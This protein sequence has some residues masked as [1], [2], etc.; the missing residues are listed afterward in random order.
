LA[1]QITWLF[2]L[3]LAA[4]VSAGRFRWGIPA[5]PSGMAVFLWTGWLLTH[6]IVFSWAKGIFHEY[7][8]TIM[9]PAVAALA[10]MSVVALWKQWFHGGR[11]RGFLLPVALALTA[12]WQAYILRNNYPNASRWLLPMVLAGV[13]TATVG[14]LGLRW[15]SRYRWLT[16]CAKLAAGVGVAVLLI[17][18]ASWSLATLARPGNAVMPAAPEPTW[19]SDRPDRGP[20]RRL[21]FDAAVDGKSRL[22]DFLRANRREE[23]FLMVG[24]SVGPIAPIIIATGEPAI[25]LG[26]FLGADPVVTK[27]EFARMVEEGQVRFVFAGGPGGPPG[28]GPD[29]G[30][31]PSP[32]GGRPPGPGGSPGRESNAEIMAWVR[33]HGKEV[34]PRLWQP[35]EPKDDSRP[36]RPD[37]RDGPGGRGRPGGPRGPME[38]LYDCRPELGLVNPNAH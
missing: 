18:P 33:E 5:D 35:E 23:R 17:G 4:L 25:A 29:G 24:P 36:S 21:P 2:P 20:P 7:Y 8:T 11:W 27:D 10:G 22:V 28:R 14:M 31:M 34:D 32:G 3:A 38:R 12:A 16:R 19:F 1:G 6:W 9:A 15:S 26:G 37:G 30:A 13:G